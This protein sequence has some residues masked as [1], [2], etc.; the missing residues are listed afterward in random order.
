MNIIKSEEFKRS[1]ARICLL[2]LSVWLGIHDPY[3]TKQISI[4]EIQMNE[5]TA[6]KIQLN[7]VNIVVTETYTGSNYLIGLMQGTNGMV[8][9]IKM[10][11][12]NNAGMYYDINLIGYCSINSDN[13]VSITNAFITN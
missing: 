2:T 10:T 6:N 4:E 1:T 9:P 13:Q 11:P 3:S 8:I 5:C 7:N 12:E